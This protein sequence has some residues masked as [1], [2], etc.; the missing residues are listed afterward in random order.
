MIN[1]LKI[2]FNILPYKSIKDTKG[3]IRNYFKNNK[4]TMNYCDGSNCDK[5]KCNL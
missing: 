4:V 1:R 5:C 2:Y 3:R